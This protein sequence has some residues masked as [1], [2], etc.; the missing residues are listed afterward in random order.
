M[1]WQE[2]FDEIAADNIHG[3]SFL[4][5]RACEAIESIEN[6]KELDKSLAKLAQLQPYMAPFY[7]LASFLQEHKSDDI[8]QSVSLWLRN[9]D[10]DGTRVAKM[11][12]KIIKGKR[13]LV[14]SASS[15][16]FAALSEAK[17]VHVL[18]TESRPK[19]EGE[20]LCR[21][22]CSQGLDPRLIIDAAAGYMMESIDVVL[23]S[24]DG[25]G[26]FGLVHK[27]GSYP[28]ALAA[29]DSGKEVIVLAPPQKWW[30]SGFRLPPQPLRNSREISKHCEAYNYYFDITPLRLITQI[31]K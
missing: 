27:I 12:A 25:I 17:D 2:I 10:E 18:V 8:S 24:A 13:V 7:H 14:H 6:P 20:K 31:I 15:L 1:T 23:F 21:K 5:R 4:V 19:R 30:P 9:F 3:A 22:L 11:A 29:R 26:E 28:I 16:V